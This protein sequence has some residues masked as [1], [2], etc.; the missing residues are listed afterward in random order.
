MSRFVFSK[1]KLQ[2]GRWIELGGR[3]LSERLV[4]KM[5]QEFMLAVMVA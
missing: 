4:I 5:W 3:L 2:S 1:T